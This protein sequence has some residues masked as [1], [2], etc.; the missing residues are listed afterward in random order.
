MP[1]LLTRLARMNRT[2]VFLGTVVLALIGLFLPGVW[3]ALLLFAVVAALAAL[4][5]QTWAVT[6]PALRVIRLL[7]LA[8]LAVIATLKLGGN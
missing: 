8:G 7:I 6:P 5:S 4:L 2:R 3:G 1:N